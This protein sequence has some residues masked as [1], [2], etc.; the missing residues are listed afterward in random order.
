MLL[1][2]PLRS[3]AEELARRIRYVELSSYP[4]LDLLFASGMYLTEHAV[5]D[6]KRRFNL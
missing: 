6:A 4:G 1:S 2:T 5:E 3:E